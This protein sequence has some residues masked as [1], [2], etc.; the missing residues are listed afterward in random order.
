MDNKEEITILPTEW[1][2]YS[3][4]TAYK[5]KL[6]RTILKQ[7]PDWTGIAKEEFQE[8]ILLTKMEKDEIIADKTR[9]IIC[10]DWK[11]ISVELYDGENLDKFSPIKEI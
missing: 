1:I 8:A 9:D 10:S 6:A 5:V 2:D 4:R 7:S 3:M 11:I